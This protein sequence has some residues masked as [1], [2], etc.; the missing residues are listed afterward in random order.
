[1]MYDICKEYLL[2]LVDSCELFIYLQ[3]NLSET[4]KNILTKMFLIAVALDVMYQ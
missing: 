2:F 1:M 4:T 3:I